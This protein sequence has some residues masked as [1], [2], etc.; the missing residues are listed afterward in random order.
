MSCVHLKN[1]Y[2]RIQ[3]SSHIYDFFLSC[4]FARRNPRSGYLVLVNCRDFCC[5]HTRRYMCVVRS[6]QY[7]HVCGECRCVFV[8]IDRII[9]S[10]SSFV[11]R[12]F[13]LTAYIYNAHIM[14]LLSVGY[15]KAC[16][17][18]MIKIP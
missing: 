3:H 16:I 12:V 7:R 1:V 2:I 17:A 6:V 18:T 10:D 11:G 8:I 9:R 13:P 4:F 15:R 5:V 14:Y